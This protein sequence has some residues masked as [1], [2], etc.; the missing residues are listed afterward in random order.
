M[1]KSILWLH[2]RDKPAFV[3]CPRERR[4]RGRMRALFQDHW[5]RGP[6]LTVVFWPV[7]QHRCEGHQSMPIP[8]RGELVW[9]VALPPSQPVQRTCAVSDYSLLHILFVCFLTELCG[10]FDL[11][12]ESGAYDAFF[13]KGRGAL[14]GNYEEVSCSEWSGWDG[15][16]LWNGACL[17]G[18]SVGL[19]PKVGCG[20]TGRE[21]SPCLH[22][23]QYCSYTL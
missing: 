21:H 23:E 1:W 12:Q 2:R 13:P 18:E 17:A 9:S 22:R 3:W 14:S 6:I 11:C 7:L 10:S 19:W 5:Y 4:C 20:N 16:A 15:P 8:R